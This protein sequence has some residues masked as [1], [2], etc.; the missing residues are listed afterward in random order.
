MRRLLLALLTAAALVACPGLAG[1]V[2]PPPSGACAQQGFCPPQ[3]PI[4]AMLREPMFPFL[5]TQGRWSL[6]PES[7]HFARSQGLA[8]P[9]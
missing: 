4:P 8:R 1:C 2:C 7:S 9:Q 6:E 3:T 5:D